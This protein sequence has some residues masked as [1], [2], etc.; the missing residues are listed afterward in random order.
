MTQ[1]HTCFLL[2]FRTSTSL[3]ILYSWDKQEYLK[4]Q[5]FSTCQYIYVTN[6]IF[7]SCPTF[8]LH[9]VPV[10]WVRSFGLLQRDFIEKLIL[11]ILPFLNNLVT[12]PLLLSMKPLSHLTVLSRQSNTLI[13][14]IK[15]LR[16]RSTFIGKHILISILLSELYNQKMNI[17]TL[18]SELE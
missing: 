6:N 16:I 18:Y 15:I 10:G 1:G 2:R 3:F 17:L 8:S 12:R 11:G 13:F 9:L 5:C 4:C 14:T 7:L